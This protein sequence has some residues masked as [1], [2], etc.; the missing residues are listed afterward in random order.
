MIFSALDVLIRGVQVL[1][2]H[3]KNWAL[4]LDLACF[5]C[6]TIKVVTQLQ[7]MNN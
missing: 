2:T 5:E 7:L 4:P 3:Q 1:F 6:L